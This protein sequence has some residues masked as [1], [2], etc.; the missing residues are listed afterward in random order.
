MSK[1]KRTA[2]QFCGLLTENPRQQGGHNI[3]CKK[4]NSVPFN[5]LSLR[6]KRDILLKE[7]NFTCTIC[8]NSKHNG[9]PIPL[10]IDHIDGNSDNDCKENLRIICPNC[11]ALTP[12]FK[13]KNKNGRG[14]KRS[15]LF[16]KV[17]KKKLESLSKEEY[18]KI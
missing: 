6:V 15:L 4:R 17:A 18:N 16:L 5:D 10:E 11:H 14:S 13:S 12:N 7:C 2:C 3:G 8:N 1:R 9:F